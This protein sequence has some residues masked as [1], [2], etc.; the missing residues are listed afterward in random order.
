[1]L[2]VKISLSIAATNVVVGKATLTITMP[3]EVETKKHV[4]LLVL[5]VDDM[6]AQ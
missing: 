3:F 4:V 5:V 1:M 2:T 6:N